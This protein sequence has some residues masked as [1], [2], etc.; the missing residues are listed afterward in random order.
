MEN[1]KQVKLQVFLVFVL[2][3]C[4]ISINATNKVGAGYCDQ[5]SLKVLMG[6]DMVD[7][8]SVVCCKELFGD[9]NQLLYCYVNGVLSVYTVGDGHELIFDTVVYK[10]HE[11][12]IDVTIKRAN[13]PEMSGFH[14]IS[15][16]VQLDYDRDYFMHVVNKNGA[17]A[18]FFNKKSFGPDGFFNYIPVVMND[19]TIIFRG[20]CEF[21]DGCPGF[22]EEIGYLYKQGVFTKYYNDR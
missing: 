15:I 21:P 4:T 9:E 3:F 11:E 7:D 17:S 18:L 16:V 12:I 5:Y 19:S 22:Q 2:I 20:E 10:N 8:E 14:V 6:A 1:V 13:V